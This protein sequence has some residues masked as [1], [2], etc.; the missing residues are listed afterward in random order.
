MGIGYLSSCRDDKSAFIPGVVGTGRDKPLH[1]RRM[2][3]T[4]MRIAFPKAAIPVP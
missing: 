4:A 2:S 3:M 1:T